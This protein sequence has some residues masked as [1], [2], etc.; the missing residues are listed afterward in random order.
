[1]TA[2]AS[3]KTRRPPIAVELWRYR[4]M[5]RNLAVRNLKVK[6]QRSVLGFVWT[7]LN[8]L[9][10]VGILIAIFTTVVRIPIPHYWA[11]LLSG[12]FVWNFVQQMLSTGTYVIAEH[13]PLRR[14]VAFPSEVLVL[15]ATLSRLVEFGVEM[16]LALVVL[17]AFHHGGVPASFVVLPVLLVLQ[18][19]L[20]LG[21]V[22][23]VAALAVFYHDVQH[24]IPA[25]LLT[26]FYVS[27]VFYPAQLVPEAVR[28]LYFLNPVAGLLTLYHTV[29]YEAAFPS[30]GALAATAAVCA[31]IFAGGY[32][33]FSRYKAVFAEVV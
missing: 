1:M 6:Y 10:T 14:S 25:V 32:A 29:L 20:A 17:V 7:L 12:Y 9:L 8:P 13:G 4:E 31:G 2:S 19:L 21:L 16:L 30:P 18:V 23:P 11:F 15:G 24:A 3:A 28:H 27:P 22:L 33:V 5:L 26:L